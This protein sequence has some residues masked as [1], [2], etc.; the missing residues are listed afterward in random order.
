MIEN[1]TNKKRKQISYSHKFQYISSSLEI[2]LE[3]ASSLEP[4]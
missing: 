2:L 4:L 3:A 1:K